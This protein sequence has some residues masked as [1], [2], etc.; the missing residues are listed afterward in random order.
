MDCSLVLG[1]I[2]VHVYTSKN[3]SFDSLSP[4]VEAS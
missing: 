1:G 2:A 3:L 4:Y